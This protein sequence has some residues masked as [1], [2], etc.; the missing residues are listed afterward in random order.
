MK[1]APSILTAP[2]NLTLYT[3]V[4]IGGVVYTVTDM[5]HTTITLATGWRGWLLGLRWRLWCVWFG[6]QYR[7][8]DWLLSWR[9]P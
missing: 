5:R 1:R 6:V 8:R 3:K 2:S 4:E 9:R 7:V